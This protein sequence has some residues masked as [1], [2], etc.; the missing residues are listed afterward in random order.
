MDVVLQA[1]ASQLLLFDFY[2][3]EKN[4]RPFDLKLTLG[5]IINIHQTKLNFLAVFLKNFC[6]LRNMEQSVRMY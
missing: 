4:L 5:Y 1:H 3:H 6:R 2:L